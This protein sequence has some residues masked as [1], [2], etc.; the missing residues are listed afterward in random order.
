MK[1]NELEEPLQEYPPLQT[2]RKIQVFVDYPEF[3]TLTDSRF[4]LTD[5]VEK[6]DIIYI[7]EHFKDFR[8]AFSIMCFS[9]SKI[10]V[11]YI[12]HIRWIEII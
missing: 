4:E 10:F 9:F 3:P 5:D 1:D 2:D 11:F 7:R 8:Y 6:A 12:I